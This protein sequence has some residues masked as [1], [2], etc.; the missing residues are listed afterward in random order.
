MLKPS[1]LECNQWDWCVR[2]ERWQI[3]VPSFLFMQKEMKSD[4]SSMR[5]L[6]LVPTAALKE[7]LDTL[8][9]KP[10]QYRVQYPPIPRHIS[11]W[12]KPGI[13][14]WISFKREHDM[15]MFRIRFYGTDQDL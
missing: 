8:N 3:S 13:P 12:N 11:F 2:H 5:A 6:V 9:D 10:D 7:W 14:F 1:V 15:L 4:F